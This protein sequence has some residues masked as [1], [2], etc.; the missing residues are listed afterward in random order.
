[1]NTYSLLCAALAIDVIILI[2]GVIAAYLRIPYAIEIIS[3]A[4]GTFAL[5]VHAIS[6]TIPR[7]NG[8]RNGRQGAR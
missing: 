7:R 8:N 2:I 4:L 6:R 3:A 5:L 1:M